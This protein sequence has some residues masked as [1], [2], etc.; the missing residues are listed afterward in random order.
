MAINQDAHQAAHIVVGAGACLDLAAGGAGDDGAPELGAHQAAR[1]GGRVAAGALGEVVHQVE[2]ADDGARA[3]GAE[4]ADIEVAADGARLLMV[5]PLPSKTPV[6]SA[7]SRVSSTADVPS[8]S[9]HKP[10]APQ[11]PIGTQPPVSTSK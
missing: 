9:A 4:Q 6:K 1:M 7:L 8:L 2:I 11:S 10:S 3:D 5:L